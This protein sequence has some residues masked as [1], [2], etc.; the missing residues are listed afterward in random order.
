MKIE[1]RITASIEK[2]RAKINLVPQEKVPTGQGQKGTE[3]KGQGR[4]LVEVEVE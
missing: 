3:G 2:I 1:S 4:G